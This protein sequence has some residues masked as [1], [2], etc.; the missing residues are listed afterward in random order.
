MFRILGGFF[1]AFAP[2]DFWHSLSDKYSKER[3]RNIF[4]QKYLVSPKKLDLVARVAENENKIISLSQKNSFSLYVSVP[5]CPTRCSYCSFV[6]HSIE[7][8][9][10]T[11]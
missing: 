6:S 5:F 11:C 1:T 7:K 2:P 10:G 3:A 9:G 8:G 4:E